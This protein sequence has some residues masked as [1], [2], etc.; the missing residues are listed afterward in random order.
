MNELHRQEMEKAAAEAKTKYQQENPE[1]AGLHL[2]NDPM[3]LI[4]QSKQPGIVRHN[5]KLICSAVCLS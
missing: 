2:K 3:K 1:A 5:H 4:E